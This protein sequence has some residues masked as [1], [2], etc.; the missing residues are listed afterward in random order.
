MHD[1]LIPAASIACF[2]H[3]RHLVLNIILFSSVAMRNVLT[4]GSSQAL[5][6]LPLALPSPVLDVAAPPVDPVGPNPLFYA[7]NYVAVI[8]IRNVLRVVCRQ[9]TDASLVCGRHNLFQT[10]GLDDRTEDTHQVRSLRNTRPEIKRE[11]GGETRWIEIRQH[12]GEAQ[13]DGLVFRSPDFGP[14]TVGERA[15]LRRNQLACARLEGPFS[16]SFVTKVVVSVVWIW[17]LIVMPAA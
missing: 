17:K 15:S 13:R 12:Q 6:S 7:P 9:R 5:R 1:V 2:M 8:S 14:K 3:S 11:F 10:R 4:Q 16:F